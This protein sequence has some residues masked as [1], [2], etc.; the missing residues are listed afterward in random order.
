LSRITALVL[1]MPKNTFIIFERRNDA[2][3]K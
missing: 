2:F 1:I 3:I